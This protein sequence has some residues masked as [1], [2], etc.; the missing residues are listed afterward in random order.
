MIRLLEA[1]AEEGRGW[2]VETGA[3]RRVPWRGLQTGPLTLS[4]GEIGE[5]CHRLLGIAPDEVGAMAERVLVPAVGERATLPAVLLHSTTPELKTF[6]GDLDALV[7]GR[8]GGDFTTYKEARSVYLGGPDD[9]AV[10]RTPAW[11]A[12][13]DALGVNGIK[14]EDAEH[15]YLSHALLR[16]AASSRG[17]RPPASLERLIELVGRAPRRMR[18]YAFELEMQIFLLWLARRAGVAE[19]AVEANGPAL[20]AAWNRKGV[21]HPTVARARELPE[22]RDAREL[23]RLEGRECELARELGIEV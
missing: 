5:L 17:E 18:L 8:R 16:L 10:G 12:A 9:V 20:S 6:D 15:Y 22:P 4:R 11:R 1:P 7:S 3:G 13:V 2:W 23:L 14:L 21:L 19:L